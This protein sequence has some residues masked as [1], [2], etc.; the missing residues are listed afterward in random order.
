MNGI[1]AMAVKEA[2][3]VSGFGSGLL[4]PSA[5]QGFAVGTLLSGVCLLMAIGPRRRLRRVR[6]GRVTQSSRDGALAM[7]AATSASSE[8]SAAAMPG[9]LADESAEIVAPAGTYGRDEGAHA[10]DSKNNGHRS[11]HKLSDPHASRR[12]EWRRSAPRH[13][14]RAPRI[15][16]MASKLPSHPVSVRD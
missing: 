13:A 4:A 10:H 2:A 12:P 14:A 11:K 6:R 3:V 1:A 9:P 8:C 15:G 7:A 16:R 5:V